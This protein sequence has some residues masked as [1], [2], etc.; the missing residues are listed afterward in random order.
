MFTGLIEATGR[1]ASVARTSTGARLSIECPFASELESGDSVSVN[2]VCLTVTEAGGDRFSADVVAETLRVS[3]LSAA[4]A[5]D[6]VNL[7]RALRL[8][9]RLGGHLVTGHVDAVAVVESC[10][11]LGAGAELTLAVPEPLLPQI[12]GKGSIAVD[13]ASLTV[14]DVTGI[15]VTIS[16]IPETLAATRAGDYSAGM[17]VNIETDLLAKHVRRLIDEAASRSSGP[18]DARDHTGQP[19]TSEPGSGLTIERLR[20]LGF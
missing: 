4:R 17:R 19:D 15:T 9:D 16:L 7:E 13:G 6:R 12:V 10:R 3:T 8:G 2:G 18:A 5:G 14:A 20:E 1:V 11:R